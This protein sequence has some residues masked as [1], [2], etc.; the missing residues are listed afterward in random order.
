MH[1]TQLG[2][3]EIHDEVLSPVKPKRHL[4]HRYSGELEQIAQFEI[5][6]SEHERLLSK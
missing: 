2:R 5:K 4:S 3:Q 6:Q 1:K